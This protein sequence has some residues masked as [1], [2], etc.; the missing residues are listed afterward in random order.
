MELEICG[1][2]E[3]QPDSE[4]QKEEQNANY[5]WKGSPLLSCVLF[6]LLLS[7]G[8]KEAKKDRGPAP[9]RDGGCR[10]GAGCR[11]LTLLLALAL[12]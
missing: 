8:M 10:R 2:H 6:L 12:G 7:P 3:T 4:E 1:E 5:S 11:A 9:S